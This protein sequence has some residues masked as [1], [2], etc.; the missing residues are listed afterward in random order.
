MR[1]EFPHPD[2]LMVVTVELTFQAKVGEVDDP[3]PL[4]NNFSWAATLPANEDT[5]CLFEEIAKAMREDRLYGYMQ[6]ACAANAVGAGEWVGKTIE[7]LQQEM[8][9]DHEHE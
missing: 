6:Q 1:E 8:E 9:N 4:P 7:D 3:P 5:A 2:D